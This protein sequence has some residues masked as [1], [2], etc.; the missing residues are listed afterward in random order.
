MQ[1]T[2]VTRSVTALFAV[3]WENVYTFVIAWAALLHKKNPGF[4]ARAFLLRAGGIL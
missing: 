4:V 3:C 2:P 1:P